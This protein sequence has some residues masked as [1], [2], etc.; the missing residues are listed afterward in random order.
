MGVSLVV[1]AVLIVLALIS[2]LAYREYLG[3]RRLE[4]EESK[5]GMELRGLERDLAELRRQRDLARRNLELARLRARGRMPLHKRE[6]LGLRRLR[7]RSKRT[8]IKEHKAGFDWD[9]EVEE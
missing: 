9:K 7:S 4:E 8:R 5:L 3:K 6:D 2:A 1:L